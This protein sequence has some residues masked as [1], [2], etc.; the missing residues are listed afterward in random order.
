ML[1][2]FDMGG[3][4]TTTFRMD[5][6]YDKLHLTKD[7]FFSICRMND[8]DIWD[9]LEKGN[10]SPSNFWEE[11]NVRIAKLQRSTYDGIVEIE[12]IVKLSPETDIQKVPTV[13]HDLFRLCFHP[14]LNEE[15]VA[16]IKELSKKHRVVCGTN[17]IQSHWENHMERGDYSY[18][19]QTYASNKISATKPNKEFFELILDAENAKPQE[20]FFTDDKEDNCKAAEAVGINAIQFTTAAELRKAWKKYL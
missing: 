15:T 14:K 13:Q 12:D 20:A 10:I 18:F 4:V 2:I 16:L 8:C 1:F 6:I 7:D 11:F 9:K 3:V 5:S 17:T 19:Q